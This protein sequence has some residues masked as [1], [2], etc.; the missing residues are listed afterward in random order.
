MEVGIQVGQRRSHVICRSLE[1]G[2]HAPV[3]LCAFEVL[4]EAQLVLRVV[5]IKGVPLNE[6]TQL[7]PSQRALVDGCHFVSHGRGR[8]DSQEVLHLERLTS[9]R[10][11]KLQVFLLF[12]TMLASE[13]E[14]VI[15]ES[16]RVQLTETVA[17]GDPPNS[18]ICL[19]LQFSVPSSEFSSLDLGL[20]LEIHRLI[21]LADLALGRGVDTI[22]LVL[23]LEAVQFAVVP[24]LLVHLTVVAE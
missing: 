14:P 18:A 16:L 10:V 9:K 15:L 13:Q 2:Q 24:V 1:S 20:L 12:A 6:G 23:N 17:L 11:P 7:K 5:Q 3:D 22:S 8:G 4:V 21:A 19:G